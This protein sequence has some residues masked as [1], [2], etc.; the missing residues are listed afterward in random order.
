MLTSSGE[1]EF[2][3]D[4]GCVHKLP[5]HKCGVNPGENNRVHQLGV[6]L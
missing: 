2:L 6:P 3:A 1:N 5:L 4:S